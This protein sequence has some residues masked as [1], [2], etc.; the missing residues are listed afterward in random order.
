MHVSLCCDADKFEVVIGTRG[1]SRLLPL[2]DHCKM[3]EDNVRG[4]GGEEEG[5]AAGGEGGD[6]CAL[7][8]RRENEPARG[9]VPFHDPP[10][11]LL[12]IAGQ[13]MGIFKDHQLEPGIERADRGIP[14]EDILEIVDQGLALLVEVA[15]PLVLLQECLSLKENV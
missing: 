7:V 12:G 4:D 5:Q 11:G 15:Y 14:F 8:S 10:Q 13:G 1:F 9:A 6:K 3:G 2:P